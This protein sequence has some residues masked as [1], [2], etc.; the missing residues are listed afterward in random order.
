MEKKLGR[1]ASDNSK[2]VRY[3]IRL[4]KETNDIL[5]KYCNQKNIDISEGIRTGIKKLDD[6]IKK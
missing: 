3:T 6:E 1:P 5:L 2:K 4:D